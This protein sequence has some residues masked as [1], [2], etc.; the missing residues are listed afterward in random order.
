MIKI[1]F[2]IYFFFGYLTC[3]RSELPG[4]CNYYY[5]YSTTLRVFH[6]SIN[7]LPFTG[8]WVTASL[9]KSPGLFSVFWPISTLLSFGW[10][11]LVFL[12]PILSVPFP[13]FWWLYR[14]Y[15]SQLVSPSLS[16][17]ISFSV[18]QQDTSTYL[19]FRLPSI[20]LCGLQGRQSQ[21]FRKFS[22]FCW[23]SLYLVVW[24]RLFSFPFLFSGYFC[25]VDAYDVCIVSALVF[26]ILNAGTS[27]SFFFS[28]H[29]TVCL[30]RLWDVRPYATSWVFLQSCS[31]VEVFLSS[32][33]RMVPII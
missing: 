2:K 13:V 28:W 27:S 25:S 16:C 33:L 18:P 26:V 12:F 23:L 11:L 29:N 22:V 9:L 24:S 15:R 30:C 19:S 31:F 20:L 3:R 5:H 1:G 10:S 7:W 17:S 14:A 6:I 8:V 21:Q 32:T 4:I